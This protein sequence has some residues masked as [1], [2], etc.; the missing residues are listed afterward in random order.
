MRDVKLVI[1]DRTIEIGPDDAA[2]V[3]SVD[4]SPILISPEYEP[5]DEV[6]IYSP[7]AVITILAAVMQDQRLFEF[8]AEKILSKEEEKPKLRIIQGGKGK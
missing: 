3:L 5:D 1:G 8:C 2:L 7:M 6:S 4:D